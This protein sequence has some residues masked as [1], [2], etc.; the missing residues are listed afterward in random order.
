MLGRLGAG[1][2]VVVVVVVGWKPFPAA[3][4]VVD[5]RVASED[6]IPGSGA[7]HYSISRWKRTN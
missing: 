1:E 5:E 7:I 4:P 3:S 2:R 6:E